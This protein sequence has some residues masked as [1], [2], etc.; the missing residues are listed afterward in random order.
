[1]DGALGD[2]DDA[3]NIIVNAFPSIRNDDN[4]S[5]VT[6]DVVNNSEKRKYNEDM[7]PTRKE[8]DDNG[9]Y[10]RNEMGVYDNHDK[11]TKIGWVRDYFFTKKQSQIDGQTHSAMMMRLC[12]PKQNVTNLLHKYKQSSLY[13]FFCSVSYSTTFVQTTNGMYRRVSLK[14]DEVSLTLDPA[15]LKCTVQQVFS[16]KKK[17]YTTEIQLNCSNIVKV[18]MNNGPSKEES[19]VSDD[20]RMTDNVEK[21]KT[22]GNKDDLH[23]YIKHRFGIDMGTINEKGGEEDLKKAVFIFEEFTKQMM[24]QNKEFKNNR[25]KSENE[26]IKNYLE[27]SKRF[28]RPEAT[29]DEMK[30]FKSLLY[31]EDLKEIVDKLTD[32]LR[33]SVNRKGKAREPDAFPVKGKDREVKSSYSSSG[34]LFREVAPGDYRDYRKSSSIPSYL[35]FSNPI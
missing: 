7:F 28:N 27:I 34:P 26:N 10:I 14:M 5:I 3:V 23:N 18:E 19:V 17:N 20:V 1:M 6:E 15:F 25:L 22:C 24:A 13:R 4:E 11:R 9:D 32:V 8:I 30:R 21:D 29:K 33:Y 12:I 2:R 16:E 31:D 35:K